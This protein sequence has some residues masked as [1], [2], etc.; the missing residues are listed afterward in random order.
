MVVEKKSAK[1]S[2]VTGTFSK[3]HAWWGRGGKTKCCLNIKVNNT[4]HKSHWAHI[5]LYGRT[6]PQSSL[7][8]CEKYHRLFYRFNGRR[9]QCGPQKNILSVLKI[10]SLVMKLK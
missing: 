5:V 8:A 2:Q 3:C 1:M 7:L 10:L 9:F 6:L 4:E